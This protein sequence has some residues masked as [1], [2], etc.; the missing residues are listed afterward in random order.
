MPGSDLVC[1]SDQSTD[2]QVRK[3][4]AAGCQPQAHYNIGRNIRQEVAKVGIVAHE[5]LAAE[6]H[7]WRISPSKREASSRNSS[8]RVGAEC[9]LDRIAHR[10]CEGI[11]GGAIMRA[12]AT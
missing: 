10:E 9:F 11:R 4:Q 7:S 1:S 12:S 2:T 6:R 8:A 5:I 3:L